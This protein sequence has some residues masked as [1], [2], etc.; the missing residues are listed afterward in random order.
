[1]GALTA[2]LLAKWTGGEW[3][4]GAPARIGSVGIDTRALTRGDLFV[5]L[6][7]GKRDGHDFLAQAAGAGAAGALVSAP[8]PGL[9]IPQ[10]RVDDTCTALQK[11]GA[12]HRSHFAKPL[13]GITG[14]C[15]K[16]STKDLLATLL[17]E[18]TL[19]TEG[20]LNNYLG[21]PL[22]L[23]RLRCC[24]HHTGVVE[25]GISVAGEMA[26]LARIARPDIAIVTNVSAAHLEGL[27]GTVEAVAR[28]KAQL[29][30]IMGADKTAIF[31]AD[32]LRHAPF[33]ELAAHCIVTAPRGT[34]VE[35][36]GA[37]YACARYHL[38]PRDDSGE[39]RLDLEVPG[40]EPL[41]L[42]L[43]RL[44]AG[45]LSNAVLALTAAQILGVN[46]QWM[47]VRLGH[48]R[49]AAFRGEVVRIGHVDFYVDCYNANPASMRDSVAAFQDIY[50]QHRRLYML[51]CMNELGELSEQLHYEVGR[52]LPI[53]P[54]DRVC[55]IGREAASLR[56]GLLDAGVDPAHVHTARVVD[57]ARAC[58]ERFSADGGAVLLKGSRG[59]RLELLLPDAANER[60]ALHGLAY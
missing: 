36:P 53:A 58:L 12:A 54:A 47:Q 9:S 59:Y 42:R 38:G 5:A 2:E 30:A 24:R 44:S 16:T 20:N 15:G 43:P 22:T 57:D 28:E 34:P 46:Q 55:V 50:P 26:V 32:C 41:T 29:P 60:L 49:P 56:Q 37:N 7:T 45:M 31:P 3:L 51:G 35:L 14:S 8:V 23:L 17:G 10:L 19:R 40:C 4:H 18:D 27:G 21:L 6:K 25:V 33:R 13:V 52:S 39:Q 48:W 11:I 1:M